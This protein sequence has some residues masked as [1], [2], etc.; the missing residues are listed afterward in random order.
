M[1]FKNDKIQGIIIKRLSRFLDERGWLSEFFRS[2]ELPSEYVPAMGYISVTK[3]GVVRGPH[4]HVQQA[5]LFCFMGPGDFKITLWDNR[6]A[7]ST[8]CNRMELFLGANNPGA[9]IVPYGVVHGYRCISIEPGWV[10]NCPNQ[11]YCGSGKTFPV[12]E[13]RH[14]ADP[15]NIFVLDEK[16]RRAVL[17]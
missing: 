15:D 6:P 11:L 16:V 3:P 14:E 5:D 17:S 7:S 4:E 1:V 8:Y 12:D 2:D 13:I 10:I 9:I